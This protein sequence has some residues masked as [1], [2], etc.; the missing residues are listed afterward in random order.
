MLQEIQFE[1]MKGQ[2]TNQPLTGKDIFIGH[3]GSGKTTRIQ[4]VG[5]SMLGYVPGQG[6]TPAETFKLATGE[7]M[8]V[9]LKASD[10]QFSRCFSK[11]TKVDTKSGLTTVSIKEKLSVSP[12][13][14]ER[15]ETQ[16]KER[17]AAEIGSFPVMLDFNEF[18]NLSDAKRRDFIYSLS[19]ISSNAWNREGVNQYLEDNLLT[20]E[21]KNNNY[22]QFVE[23]TETIQDVMKQF[24]E[25]Y[26]IHDGLQSM[27][28]YVSSQLSLWNSKKKDAQGAV[29]QI[30]DMKNQIA[31]T[32][33][34]I[35]DNK[36][37]LE[38]LQKQL[39]EVEKKISSD[40]EK[41]KAIDT[42]LK[43]M[44][45]LAQLIEQKKAEN[46]NTDTTEIEK[47]I[48][49]LQKQL[50]ED[51]DYAPRL[52]E[53]KKKVE[54]NRK[55]KADLKPQQEQLE[56]QI[57]QMQSGMETLESSIKN[58]TEL[59][60]SCIIDKRIGCPKDF[61]PFKEFVDQKRTEANEEIAKV[62]NQFNEIKQKRHGLDKEIEQDENAREVLLT[63]S[64]Q[65]SKKNQELNKKITELEKE[66]DQRFTAE[67]RRD[68][69]IKLLEEERTRL[70]NQKVEP[71]G[72]ISIMEKQAEGIR[73]R[74]ESLKQ[75][76]AE[77]E[78]A[79]QTILLLHQSMLDNRKAEYK[80]ICFKS[81]NEMLGPKG[82]QGELVKGILE[83][84]KTDIYGNLKLMG[85]DF[86]P[87]FQTE[88]DTGKEIFQFG[89]INEK[90]HAVNFDALSTG[91]QT[92]FLASMM[93]TIIDRAQPKLRLLVM[94]NLNHL[95]KQNFQLL[96][97]GLSKIA[98]KLDNI[99]LAGAVEYDFTAE[100]WN[101]VD[102]TSTDEEV[103]ADELVA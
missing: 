67:E 39:V 24:P 57:M 41:K 28:D 45:E 63:K 5:L 68:N 11:H 60:G 36:K 15:T 51:V 92:V 25:S 62:Q 93:M 13:K 101:V 73:N 54:S 89:W 75:S 70:M 6:K 34:N 96:I 50:V 56:R 33:R 90:A 64:Q 19:P 87:F 83:P 97:N 8:T 49:V 17:I 74:F 86:E 14:G 79:K 18:L 3:N 4:G 48:I 22:E 85:F 32:D 12:G 100:G 27:L 99:I 80:A 98:D 42:R 84:I 65:D 81:I 35:A 77:K 58:I 102:L 61:T 30:S 21:L 47:K 78:K 53:L 66:R 76:V 23:M 7:I 103:V 37:D 46:I 40:S 69:Q 16:K 2:T 43:R 20:L 29:R 91:Q 10:F 59:G 94:D 71:I 44:E 82:I 95:D 88:S 31:E 52:A 9:G 1:N 38:E 55:L 72:D 26:D